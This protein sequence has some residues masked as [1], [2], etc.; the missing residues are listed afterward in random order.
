MNCVI[1]L[2]KIEWDGW[3]EIEGYEF[4]KAIYTKKCNVTKIR[5]KSVKVEKETLVQDANNTSQK[6]LKIKGLF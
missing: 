1:H 5:V 6:Q 3:N 4:L 2:N